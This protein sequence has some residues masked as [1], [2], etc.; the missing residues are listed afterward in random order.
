[1]TVVVRR[2]RRAMGAA[3]SLSV[4]VVVED[5]LGAPAVGVKI[6]ASSSLVIA[7]AVPDNV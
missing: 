5:V 1:M 6:R 7:A 2:R 3:R 4:N